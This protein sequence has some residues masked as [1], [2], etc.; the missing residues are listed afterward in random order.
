[1]LAPPVRKARNKP[2]ASATGN[3]QEWHAAVAA[4]SFGRAP[5]ERAGPH[6]AGIGNQ[7]ALRRLARHATGLSAEKRGDRRT[8]EAAPKGEMARQ[9]PG[10]ISEDLDTPALDASA[11]ATDA[12]AAPPR[13]A[14]AAP[15]PDAGTAPTAGGGDCGSI[16]D[17]AYANS[18]LNYGGGGVVCDGATKCPCSFDIPPLPLR[19]GA[20]PG[21]DAIA[22]AHER[23]HL[24][25][26]DCNP[27][28]GLHRPN[29]RDPSAAMASECTHRRET[30]AEVNAILPGSTGVCKTGMTALRDLLQ[31]WVTA[32]C[33]G[34]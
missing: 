23:R 3:A 8:Q 5:I 34:P 10:L 16:C 22:V 6:Q 12:G 30:I 19:R 15:A 18:S 28:G 17:R 2:G 11:P 24:G 25:D 33:G 26:V 4:R 1:M 21:M 7:A 29:F 32:N 14:G 20:C 31:T 13:D 9:A 27:A